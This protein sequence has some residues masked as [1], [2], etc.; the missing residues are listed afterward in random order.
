MKLALSIH[1]LSIAALAPF[2][3]SQQVLGTAYGQINQRFGTAMVTVGDVNGDG[4]VDLAVG[5]PGAAGG[6]GAVHIVSGQDLGTG[7]TPTLFYVLGPLPTGTGSA[8]GTTLTTV[9]NLVGNSTPDLLVGAPNHVTGGSN[10]GALYL[11]D[12]SNFTIA[13]IITGYPNSRLGNAVAAVGDQN[14]DGKPDVIATTSATNNSNLRM[15]FVPGTALITGGSLSVLAPGGLLWGAN[16][17]GEVLATGFD[18][19][20]DGRLDFAV[21]APTNSILHIYRADGSW[22]FLG[23][24]TSGD[25]SEHAC[26]SISAGEDYD[27]DGKVDFLIGAP[28]WNPGTGTEQGR[29]IVVS[30]ASILTPAYPPVVIT[31][32]TTPDSIPAF[33][34]I[35]FGAAV[36]AS[37]DLTGDGVGEILVGCPDYRPL[38][39]F[40]PRKGAVSIFSGAT[41]TQIGGYVGNNFDYIGD[42][43][44]P[45]FH[46]FNG[47]GFPD[48]VAAG[49]LSDNPTT[50]C[51]VVKCL[52]LYPAA[53]SAYCTAKTNSQGCVPAIG[54]SGSASV[55]SAAPFTVSCANLLN[56]VSGLYFYSH[57]PG[58][59]PFQGGTFCVSTPTRRAPL[60][61]SGGS[62]SGIDCTGVLAFDFN[63]RI[64]SGVDPTLI[65]GAEVFVQ[66]WSRDSAS[67]STT[68][69]SNALRFVINP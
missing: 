14:G 49:S 25:V 32:F 60:L 13:S 39:P 9:G 69:L 15:A 43:I 65:A 21:G 35:H 18:H 24:Y 56:Q 16:Q 46:D 4:V 44:V 7:V 36:R 28:N 37:P 57:G 55:S 40:G 23:L 22:T 58:A 3:R 12:G 52:S 66:C 48:F 64:D 53:P 62:A 33:V 27:G 20:G 5:V 29:V 6:N 19:D 51:G 26:A 41:L 45:A 31:R 67:P 68:N 47:D 38:A 2:A 10:T 59:T 34:N 11:I 63:A 8:F 30:G 1:A 50:D 54:W 17:A 61:N 42:V